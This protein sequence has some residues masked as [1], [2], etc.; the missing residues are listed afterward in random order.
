MKKRIAIA[1]LCVSMAWGAMV[2]PAA[3]AK[4]GDGDAPSI[5][6]K[7]KKTSQSNALSPIHGISPAQ[8]TESLFRGSLPQLA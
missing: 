5:E 2:V 1:S 3:A 4:R 8:A 6:K 7:E